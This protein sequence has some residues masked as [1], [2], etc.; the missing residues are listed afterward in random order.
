MVLREPGVNTE[1]GSPNPSVVNEQD[2]TPAKQ[3]VNNTEEG[4]E[5]DSNPNAEPNDE[6]SEVTG[7]EAA[8]DQQN[9]QQE[10]ETQ[11]HEQAIPY[12][13]FQ[14]VNTKLTTVE[15]EYAAAKPLLEQVQAQNNIL[16]QYNISP[17]EFQSWIQYGINLRTNP[18]A[19]L[20]QIEPIYQRLAMLE[21][22]VLPQDL[23]AEVAAA[24]LSRERAVEIAKARAAQQYSGVQ[25]QWQQQGTQFNTGE[26]VRNTTTQW[27]QTKMRTDADFKEGSPL[28]N[29]VNNN[30]MGMSPSGQDANSRWQ[31]CEKAYEQGKAFM[32]QFQPRATVA[33]TR[34]RVQSR[35]STPNNGNGAPKN[36]DDAIK[37]FVTSS[38]RPNALR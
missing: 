26:I 34:L 8:A 5:E 10:N 13:R 22:K 36:M 9:E 6:P 24:T 20:A 32:K 35:Q 4:T 16:R 27:I 25:Q 29:V 15:K 7:D 18:A 2:S 14:E 30:L 11:E 38:R 19:A 21:G 31:D 3:D 17:Q 33:S 12:E 23:E 37:Q 1:G 28:W